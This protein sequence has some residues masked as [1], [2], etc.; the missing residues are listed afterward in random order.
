MHARF[1]G[2]SSEA[3]YLW[4]PCLLSKFCAMILHTS[5]VDEC[6]S[7]EFVPG[8]RIWYTVCVCCSSVF[9]APP[10]PVFTLQPL[11]EIIVIFAQCSPK[12][13]PSYA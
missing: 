7:T 13:Y 6:D 5:I 11:H 3:D 12:T 2:M 9:P 4:D 1:M 8:T 10:T